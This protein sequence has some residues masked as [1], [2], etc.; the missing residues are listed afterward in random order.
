VSLH[1]TSR[2]KHNKIR[3]FFT[4]FSK[5]SNCLSH[6]GVLCHPAQDDYQWVRTQIMTR[7]QEFLVVWQA[8][9]SNV[10]REL[11]SLSMVTPTMFSVLAR[12]QNVLPSAALLTV[13]LLRWRCKCQSHWV[14]SYQEGHD[15]EKSCH[16]SPWFSWDIWWIHFIVTVLTYIKD[17]RGPSICEGSLLRSGT[18]PLW[19][20]QFL[21]LLRYVGELLALQTQPRAGETETIGK[22]WP[23]IN[24]G[25]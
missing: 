12:R 17:P 1:A 7:I 16:T 21:F 18:L 22:P 24:I 25:S 11:I 20:S 8:C 23:N 15:P 19:S 5:V 10:V 14:R 9:S 2:S 4:K 13:I 3:K 6:L